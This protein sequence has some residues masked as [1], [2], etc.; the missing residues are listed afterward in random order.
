MIAIIEIISFSCELLDR[1]IIY[2][3]GPTL[4]IGDLDLVTIIEAIS[5]VPLKASN[6]KPESELESDILVE[7]DYLVEQP[8]PTS[9]MAYDVEDYSIIDKVIQANR[10][11][12]ELG[13]LR[14]RAQNDL[15]LE[16][17]DGLL[18]FQGRLQVPLE[19]PE[20]RT[21]LIRHVHSQPSVAHARGTKCK[22]LI[23]RKYY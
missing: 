23:S 11:A 1:Y 8:D 16:F 15:D 6:N 10:S 2:S 22:T 17:R 3:Y 21:S 19:P 4:T 20:L 12:P 5:L 7:E 14:D 18:Y 9:A 13:P